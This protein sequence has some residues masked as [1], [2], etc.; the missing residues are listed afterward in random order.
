MS[1]IAARGSSGGGSGASNGKISVNR[2]FVS[3]YRGSSMTNLRGTDPEDNLRGEGDV[4]KAG[5]AE[6][7]VTVDEAE[8]L[9]KGGRDVEKEEKLQLDAEVQLENLHREKYVVMPDS[10]L[11]LRWDLFMLVLVL[12][13]GISVP[14]RIAFYKGI[15]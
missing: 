11:R 3:G 4:R 12:Y 5:V 2:H 13:Y 8:K 1:V 14:V 6:V 15:S 7:K 9:L 10:N